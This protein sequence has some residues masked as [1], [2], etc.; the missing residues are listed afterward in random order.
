[1]VHRLGCAGATSPGAQ[2]FAVGVTLPGVPGIVAGSN[3]DIAWGFTNVTGDFLDTVVLE[4]GPTEDTYLTPDGPEAFRTREETIGV[5]GRAPHRSEQR[6]TRWGPVSGSDGLGR[7]VVELWTGSRP[8][9]VNIDVLDLTHTRTLEDAVAVCAGWYGPPQNCMLAD[10]RGRIA[11]VVSGWL[12]RR[13]GH[14]GRRALPSSSASDVWSGSLP[15]TLRPS[16]FDPESGVLVTANERTLPPGR[17]ALIGHNWPRGDRSSRIGALLSSMAARDIDEASML[18]LQNDTRFELYDA[19]RALALEAIASAPDHPQADAIEGALRA[20]DGTA[21]ASAVGLPLLNSFRRRVHALALE[22][23]L[24]PCRAEDEGFWL[25]WLGRE[26]T[27]RRLLDER[28]L[29]L[30][31]PDHEDW[32]ALLRLALFDAVAALRDRRGL[33]PDAPWG[34]LSRVRVEHPLSW[35]LGSTP[36]GVLVRWLDMPDGPVSGAGGAVRVVAG[37][38]GASQRLVV[39]PGAEGR[40]ILHIPA[41]QSGHP[42]SPWYR[43]GHRDWVDGRATPLLPGE[44]VATTRLRPGPG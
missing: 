24:D 18:A 29:H 7:P 27:V 42:L 43:A 22:P 16:V 44:P 11:W 8:D 17:A 35:A 10:A 4:P 37:D 12:P 40:G 3:G 1:M 19:Y 30:L 38:F 21:D 36:A 13:D 39:S 25:G 6:L 31:S 32:T 9:R 34:R 20:W 5:R 23:L 26:E 33:G 2:R 28:P 15:E 14:D 41:G